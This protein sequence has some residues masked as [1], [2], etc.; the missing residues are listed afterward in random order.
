M[1]I[2]IRNLQKL[3][4]IDKK[5]I[6]EAAIKLLK[7]ENCERKE[8]SITFMNDADIQ[9]IN[10]QYLGKDRPTNVISFSLQEGEYGDINPTVLGDIVISVETA[11]R[12]AAKGGLSLEEEIFFLLIHGF[13]HLLGYEHV[14]TTPTNIRKMK[15]KEKKLF[16]KIVGNASLLV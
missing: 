3:I 10:R 5:K 13:L 7:L 9:V 15:R 16:E 1:K 12:D 14:N 2:Q 11:Q 8:I 6:R 4:K